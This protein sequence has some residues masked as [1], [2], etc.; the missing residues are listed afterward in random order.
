MRSRSLELRDPGA[1]IPSTDNL[2]SD[3]ESSN[4]TVSDE[5]LPLTVAVEAEQP[6]QESERNRWRKFF[7]RSLA[8]L[9]AMSLSI[10]SHL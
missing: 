7:I 6:V 1:R 3:S 4:G 9:C 8:L 5:E 2:S 10:G